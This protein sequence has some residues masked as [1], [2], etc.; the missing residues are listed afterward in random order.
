MGLFKDIK[1]TGTDV[2]PVVSTSA[3]AVKRCADVGLLSAVKRCADECL[4]S[5][6]SWYASSI[7][8]AI[9]EAQ[10]KPVD[11]ALRT[12]ILLQIVKEDTGL[13]ED[14][15]KETLGLLPHYVKKDTGLSLTEEDMSKLL[16]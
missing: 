7:A 8:D 3:R 1:S 11:P 10:G 5:A 6:S 14:E 2:L 12:G 4:L 15:I 13:S 16:K 9:A